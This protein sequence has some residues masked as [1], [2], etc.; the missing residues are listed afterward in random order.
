MWVVPDMPGY[1]YSDRPTGQPLDSIAVAGLWAELMGVLGYAPSARIPSLIA[2]AAEEVVTA[3]QKLAC[4]RDARAVSTDPLGGLEVVA[5][6]GSSPGVP[7]KTSC[8]GVQLV[9]QRN[10]SGSSPPAP[11]ELRQIFVR[12]SQEYGTEN[13]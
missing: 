12:R 13:L 7:L 2:Q 10:R 6:C 4:D 3:F 9:M 1:G 5:R 8:T 11:R